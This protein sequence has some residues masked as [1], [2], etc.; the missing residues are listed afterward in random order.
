VGHPLYFGNFG[1]FGGRAGNFILQNADVIVAL[2]CRLSFKQTGFNFT[3]F[4]PRA[5]KIVVDVDL[6]ELKKDTIKIDLPIHADVVELMGA[7][8]LQLDQTWD[9]RQK[10]FEY[11]TNL[12]EKFPIFQE[13]HK[14]SQSVNPYYFATVLQ[15]LLKEDGIVVVG[16]SCAC[17]SVLQAGVIHPAQ[18]L[19][20]NVNCGTMGYDLPAALGAAVA[21]KTMVVCVTGDGSIQMNL[22]ELQTIVYN[23]LP[24]KIFVFNNNGYQ[25]IMQTQTN[26]FECRLSGCN[27]E[28]GVGFPNFERIAFAYDMP[29]MLIDN[30]DDLP[31]K[32]KVF[33]DQPGFGICEIIQDVSQPIEP[34]IQSKKLPDGTMV[35]PPIDDLAPFLD[36]AIYAQCKYREEDR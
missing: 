21:A 14:V 10:W 12:R 9:K 27:R 35:S 26:F 1:V 28:S 4:A 16:N 25:A 8:G 17:V 3:A 5:F 31:D 15:S 18:R 6:A 30:H 24:V 13:K 33:L 34:K 2:G 7:I 19:F 29:Y 20:G 22:Q 11:C 36:K 23:Q 32:M